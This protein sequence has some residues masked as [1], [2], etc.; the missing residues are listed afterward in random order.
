MDRLV[1]TVAARPRLLPHRG[2]AVLL[3]AQLVGG[4]GLA[5]GVTVGA[6]L[7]QN[8]FGTDFLAGFPNA[9][10]TA[11]AAIAAAAIGGISQRWSRQ[12]G[13]ACGYGVAAIGSAAAV[14]AVVMSNPVIL[15]LALGAYGAGSATTMQARY[16]GADLAAPPRQGFVM[17]V[18]L[19][20]TAA[21]V[22]AGPALLPMAEALAEKVK[23]PAIAGPFVLAAA[24]YLAAFIV[25]AVF[26]RLS[27]ADSPP[28]ESCVDPTLPT[29][30]PSM[31]GLRFGAIT[32]CGAQALMVAMMTMTPVY[33]HHKG[34]SISMTGLV[35]AVHIASM[36]LPAPLSGY[37][38]DRFGSRTVGQLAAL[39][40]SVSSLVVVTS[41]G[42][43]L[44]GMIIAL[45]LLGWGWSL[46]VVAGSS[47]V[48]NAT[49][50][51]TRARTQGRVD[52]AMSIAGA[53]AG[54]LSGFIVAMA[55]FLWLAVGVLIPALGYWLILART[56]Q[57]R[58]MR[59][60]NC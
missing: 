52:T 32:I 58:G 12:A 46:G 39:V 55:G 34:F 41:Q 2:M 14:A 8:A 1:A 59:C 33:I 48:I 29:V 44:T 16:A 15:L 36:Y 17:S 13:L 22:L 51:A 30:H 26:L 35:I 54:V 57:D 28:L 10:A 38:T 4:S 43:S 18:V 25:V 42:N 6:L 50:S 9:A 45:A 3:L 56:K 49:T 5:A 60:D 31:P 23:L 11:G 27:S 40:L 20:T 19:M 47:A 7:S 37:L 53:L 24:T 21:G